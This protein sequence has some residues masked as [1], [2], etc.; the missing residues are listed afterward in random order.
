M[1]EISRSVQN[2]KQAKK[3]VLTVQCT[4]RTDG[5]YVV[6]PYDTWQAVVWTVGV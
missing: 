1:R 2:D 4:V 5:S 6:G 3:N